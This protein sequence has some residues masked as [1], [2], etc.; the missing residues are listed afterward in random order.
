MSILAVL[1]FVGGLRYLYRMRTKR[2]QKF[3]RFMQKV[4]R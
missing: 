2:E 3:A 4:W 1:I